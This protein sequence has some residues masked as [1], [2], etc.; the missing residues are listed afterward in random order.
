MLRGIYKKVLIKLKFSDA[1]NE[2]RKQGVEIGKDTVIFNSVL[3]NTHPH[4]IKIGNNCTLTNCILLTHDASTKRALGKSRIGIISIGDN[5][6]IG[7]GSIILPNVVI[8][9]NCIIGAGAVVSKD[10]PSNSV[11]V[12][13]PCRI[14][15]NTSDYLH[16]QE[17]LMEKGIV[18]DYNS[19]KMSSSE[20]EEQKRRLT[21]RKIGFDR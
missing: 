17:A 3:D 11:V 21:N 19:S 1:I 16:S 4:L 8:G 5:C 14:I 2:Y 9:D 7:W 13:N 18:F 15:K 20:K 12:G 10:I 6:F